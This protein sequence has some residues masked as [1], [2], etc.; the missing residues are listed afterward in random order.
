[1]AALQQIARSAGCHQVSGILLPFTRP[2]NDEIHGHYQGV[3]EVGHPIQ[4]AILATELIALE[5]V[6]ALFRGQWLGAADRV[7]EGFF[8]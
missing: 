3:F 4:P 7:Y 8:G 1:V 6:R 2:W 5:N